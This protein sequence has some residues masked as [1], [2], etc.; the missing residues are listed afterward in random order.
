MADY[1]GSYMSTAFLFW[2]MALYQIRY[3]RSHGSCYKWFDKG[4]GDV[5]SACICRHI[6]LVPLLFLLHE[7]QANYIISESAEIA[8][9]S[10]ARV[11]HLPLTGFAPQLQHNLVSLTYSRCSD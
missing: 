7:S 2:A 3:D 9:E 6:C 10:H 1:K 11:F 4:S 8:G 5:H